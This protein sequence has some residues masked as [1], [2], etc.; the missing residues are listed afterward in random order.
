M[1][2]NKIVFDKN[3]VRNDKNVCPDIVTT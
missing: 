3:D 2:V 1:I